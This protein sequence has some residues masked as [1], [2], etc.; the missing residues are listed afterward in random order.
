MSAR[1]SVVIA[2]RDGAAYIADSIASV[3][4]QTV[5]PHEVIVVDDGS[6]DDSASVAASAGATVVHHP[7]PRHAGALNAGIAAASGTHLAFN[8]HDDWWLPRKLEVQLA[9]LANDPSAGAAAGRV[10]FELLGGGDAPPGFRPE[11]LH[12][13]HAARITETLLAP[14]STFE[15][16]GLFDPSTSPAH[17]VDWFARAADAGVR[18][19]IPGEPVMRKRMVCTSTSHTSARSD[20]TLILALRRSIERK[21]AADRTP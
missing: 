11:L 14:R 17:D 3:L 18:V 1:V 9:A 13:H 4:A 19:V 20:P 7:G 21:R 12:G 8:A 2:V 5:Q 15:R 16:V 6:S 10:T